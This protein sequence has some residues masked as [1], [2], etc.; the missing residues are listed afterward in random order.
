MDVRRGGGGRGGR[1]LLRMGIEENGIVTVEY[2]QIEHKR[3][4]RARL[5]AQ[6]NFAGFG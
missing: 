2:G 6:F 3:A 1:A 5:S 4:P